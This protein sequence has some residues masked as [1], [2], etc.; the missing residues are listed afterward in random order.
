MEPRSVAHERLHEEED[1]KTPSNRN[2]GFTIAVAL[3]IVGALPLLRHGGV[4]WWAWIVAAVFIGLTWLRPQLLTPL[5]RWWLKLG[6][7]LGL[8]VSPIA[9]AILFYLVITPIGVLMRLFGKAAMRAHFDPRASSYW[10]RR[11]PPGPPPDSLNN[12]F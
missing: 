12:Q 8:I 3:L 4:R 1:L 7:L 5:N 2:F 9:M 10:I 11:D 6:L